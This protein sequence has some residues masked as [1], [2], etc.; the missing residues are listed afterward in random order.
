MMEDLNFTYEI[1]TKD[2]L[3]IYDVTISE[4]VANMFL[5]YYKYQW[6]RCGCL[7]FGEY[8]VNRKVPLEEVFDGIRS[9]IMDGIIESKWTC[10]HCEEE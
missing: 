10:P 3:R 1:I 8:L 9:S 2:T 7:C 6:P 4:S 5:V